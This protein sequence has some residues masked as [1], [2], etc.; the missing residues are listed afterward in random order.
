M[1]PWGS[2]NKCPSLALP[3]CSS[4]GLSSLI[5]E[6]MTLC[7]SVTPLP[8]CPCKIRLLWPH[9]QTCPR[10]RGPGRSAR[11][12]PGFGTVPPGRQVPTQQCAHSHPHS[13]TALDPPVQS[14]QAEVVS[15]PLG[16]GLGPNLPQFHHLCTMDIDLNSD[17]HTRT[18]RE[19]HGW[20]W[21]LWGKLIQFRTC[22]FERAGTPPCHP[23]SY[24]RLGTTL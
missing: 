8:K 13:Q 17:G 11:T 9:R 7:P 14:G 6:M 12:G 10:A 22:A 21:G 16:R 2:I 18:W 23:L 1:P 19:P 5:V 24:P 3:D 4:G 15:Q 20:A